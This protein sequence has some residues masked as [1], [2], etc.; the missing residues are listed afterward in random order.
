MPLITVSDLSIGFRGRTLLDAVSCQIET[1]QRIALLGRNG[2]GKTTFM[3]I[4]C[5]QAEPDSGQATFAP[6]TRIALLPQDVPQDIAGPVRDVVALGLDSVGHESE[7]AWQAEHKLER[8]LSNM[9]LPA[10]ARFES[11]SSG[12]KR[13]V[14]LA[15]ALVSGP[16][17]LL[18]DEPTNHLDVEAINWLEDFLGRTSATLIFVTHDRM[19][20]RRLATRILE[21]DQARLFDWSCDYDTFLSRKEDLLAAEEK[22]NALFDKKLAEEEVWLRRGVKARRTRNEGRVRALEQMRR[23]RSERRTSGGKVQMAIAEA[24]R[25]G[26][27]VA[28][29]DCVTFACEQRPIVRDFSS[30]I[31]R[32]DKIG[33]FGPNGSGKTTLLQLLLGQLQ[34][35]LGTVRLGTNLQ[36]AYFD[37][38]RQQLNPDASVQE[39]VSDGYD[40]VTIGG[41]PRH[42]IGYLEEFLFSP[43]RSRTAVRYLSG[44]ECNR[45]LLAKLFAK[46]ANVI[47]LDEPTNDLDAE[48]LELLEERLVQFTGT[49]LVVSHDREFLNNVVSSTIVFENGGVKE[50]VGGYD[51]WLRQR[52]VSSTVPAPVNRPSVMA[53]AKT[54]AAPQADA[55]PD[56]RKRRLSFKERQ[57]LQGLPALIEKLEGQ[58]AEMHREMSQDAFYRQPG[59]QI[60]EQQALLKELE[61][62]LATVY[63]RWEELEPFAD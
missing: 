59:P 28:E 1:G 2:A 40:T 46:P 15:R 27:L 20:L 36:I 10:E 34:P 24:Q 16:D 33:V 32:G 25:S 6:G 17:V 38:L 35:Q 23:V 18:L 54:S 31:L 57:E 44:G 62:Q 11:L 53:T 14:L 22:Q 45:V 58:I 41:K 4:L 9:D 3:R 42:V 55:Q 39:N 19:F 29:L 48:T 13:R 51:D 26:T 12:M 21:I 30:T 37:Q 52:P 47:V 60:A 8:I 49:V 43:E 56:Q 63:I 61:E 7:T 5:G 50:Y